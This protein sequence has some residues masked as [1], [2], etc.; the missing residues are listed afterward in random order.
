MP[1]WFDL[2]LTTSFHLLHLYHD[3]HILTCPLFPLA[4][5]PQPRW[6]HSLISALNVTPSGRPSLTSLS[7]I[8][9]SPPPSLFTF[10]PLHCCFHIGFI[11]TWHHLVTTLIRL[12]SVYKTE[13]TSGLCALLRFQCL[14]WCLVRIK[15]SINVFWTNE[16]SPNP[17]SPIALNSVRSTSITLVSQAWNPPRLA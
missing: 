8:P 9:Q 5:R 13:A 14:E 3:K 16:L 2:I 17:P 15:R 1:P 11:S 7:K 10:F 6:L 12:E 4:E